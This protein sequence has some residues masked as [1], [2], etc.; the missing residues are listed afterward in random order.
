MPD[1]ALVA[2]L[3]PGFC[4]AFART[5]AREN[6]PVGLFGRSEEYLESFATELREAGHDA[7]AV[8][9]DVTDPEAVVAG[10]E[11][12]RDA[13]GPVEVLA[14][15]AST[16]TGSTGGLDPDRLEAM[17]RL[18]ACGGLLCVD[19]VPDDLREIGGTALFFG[20]TPTAATTRSRARTTPPAGRPVR[21]PS[22]RRP[23][24][25]SPT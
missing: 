11:R 16:T 15:T 25:T 13:L 12:V 21:P 4:E 5:L 14:H 10:V 2:G 1:T 18:Y 19:A 3:G 6:H 22:A 9:T 23:R 7:V 24:Y 20:P 8:P 17:W